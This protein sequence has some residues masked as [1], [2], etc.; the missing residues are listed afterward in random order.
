[1]WM[2]VCECGVCMRVSQRGQCLQVTREVPREQLA[3]LENQ[4]EDSIQRL[5]DLE[6]RLDDVVSQAKAEK[7]QGKIEEIVVKVEKDVDK[8][9]ISHS[10]EE[11]KE[12]FRFNCRSVPIGTASKILHNQEEQKTSFC[13]NQRSIPIG[14]AC[15]KTD[16]LPRPPRK[17]PWR[18]TGNTDYRFCIIQPSSVDH[19]L[20][21]LNQIALLRGNVNAWLR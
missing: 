16:F 9:E 11:Q 4:L 1:M 21:R 13:L 2:H 12:S 17:P 18:E 19:N 7:D 20:G 10:Q 6:E 3:D 8:E 5:T 14:T 15:M